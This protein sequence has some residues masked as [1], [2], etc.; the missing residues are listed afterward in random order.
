MKTQGRKEIAEAVLIA[1]LTTLVGGL[2]TWGLE[3]L[4]GSVK[5]EEPK[6]Q[7]EKKSDKTV[8]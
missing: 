1:A 5:K 4:K 7:P 8:N 2:I 3:A 6:D